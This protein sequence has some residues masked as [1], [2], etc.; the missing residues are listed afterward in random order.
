MNRLKN[1]RKE[2]K[3]SQK[4][5]AKLINMSQT[6]YS[7][8]ERMT[9]KISISTLK[10]LATFYN[11]SIDYILELTDIKEPYSKSKLLSSDNLLRLK[12]V[13]EDKDLYQE[14]IAKILKMSRKGYSHYESYYS[15]IPVNKLKELAIFYNVSVD[16]LLYL[17]D[18][19]IPHKR[20]EA[21][22]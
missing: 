6:G 11:T 16:Y 20:N 12:D 8:Y 5:L 22:K 21:I 3:L 13:R 2:K 19:R 14:D 7:Q 18:E 1:L 17:T 10:E 9:R 15:E 4:E